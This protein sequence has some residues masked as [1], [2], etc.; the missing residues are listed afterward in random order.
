MVV[1]GS[2]K[3]QPQRTHSNRNNETLTKA[4]ENTTRLTH[5]DHQQTLHHKRTITA[6]QRK[7]TM[8]PNSSWWFQ[9]PIETSAS[10]WVRIFPD[11]RG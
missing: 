6:N 1:S 9:N 7:K 10:K 3:Q 5:K 4:R 2:F 8:T 11:F